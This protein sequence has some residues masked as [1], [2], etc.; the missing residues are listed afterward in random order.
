MAHRALQLLA[1]QRTGERLTGR[2]ALA[3]AN[4]HARH[5]IGG[6]WVDSAVQQQSY[7]PGTGAVIG[8]YADA[9]DAEVA[10]AIETAAAAFRKIDWRLDRRLRA[11]ALNKLADCFEADTGVLVVEYRTIVREVALWQRP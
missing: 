7:D 5:W 10:E 8:T 6:E 1:N 2:H 11:R 3:P 4:M 9:G